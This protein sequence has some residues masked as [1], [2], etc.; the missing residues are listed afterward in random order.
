MVFLTL[1]ALVCFLYLIYIYFLL[2]LEDGEPTSHEHCQA[3][4]SANQRTTCYPEGWMLLFLKHLLFEH[5]GHVKVDSVSYSMTH[6]SNLIICGIWCLVAV[7]EIPFIFNSMILSLYKSGISLR[8][9]VN[10]IGIEQHLQASASSTVVPFNL[11]IYSHEQLISH[12]SPFD[13]LLWWPMLPEGCCKFSLS[14]WSLDSVSL[15]LLLCPVC[16][17]QTSFTML[18]HVT[19]LNL[20]GLGFGQVELWMQWCTPPLASNYFFF[21][22]NQQLFELWILSV[23]LG[24]LRLMLITLSRWVKTEV[25]PN[26]PSGVSG[27]LYSSPIEEFAFGIKYKSL[28]L[29]YVLRM[30]VA[31]LIFCGMQTK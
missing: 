4:N 18:F 19:R 5:L 21:Y 10:P 17:K 6:V 1:H 14:C 27:D 9:F 24:C 3:P 22:M 11:F 2:I 16:Q 30:I 8:Y 12:A 20:V 31:V 23:S 15:L 7:V 25:L 13:M 28:I 29:A 26:S